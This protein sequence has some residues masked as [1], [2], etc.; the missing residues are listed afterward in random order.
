[1]HAVVVNATISDFERARQA[2][3]EQGVPMVSQAP[4]FVAGYWT[5][6]E[7]DRGLGLVVFESEEAARTVAQRVQSEGPPDPEAVTLDSV[8]VREV[9]ASA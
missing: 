5:R 1:M 2:L 6:S 9:V 3:V 7:D 4:G 8:E